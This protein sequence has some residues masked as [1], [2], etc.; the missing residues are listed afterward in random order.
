MIAPLPVSPGGGAPFLG[1]ATAGSFTLCGLPA[2][3]NQLVIPF[4]AL[5]VTS[6]L[7]VLVVGARWNKL[8]ITQDQL[9]VF[10]SSA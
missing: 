3:L 4:I 8:W 2:H 6:I 9:A 1:C 5:T 7:R 10:L